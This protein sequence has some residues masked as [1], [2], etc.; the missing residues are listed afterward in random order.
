MVS[1]EWLHP[2]GLAHP[3]LIFHFSL[4]LFVLSQSSSFRLPPIHVSATA[5]MHPLT[6][7]PSEKDFSYLKSKQL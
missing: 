4:W 6:T 5:L 1:N 2:A 7:P 3:G